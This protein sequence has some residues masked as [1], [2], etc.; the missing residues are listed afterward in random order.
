MREMQLFVI[1]IWSSLE[2]HATPADYAR[3]GG[4]AEMLQI[5]KKVE[6]SPSPT[7][8]PVQSPR[9]SPSVSVDED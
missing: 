5:M 7:I 1:G 8:S 2:I 4:K 6:P 3:E 9:R